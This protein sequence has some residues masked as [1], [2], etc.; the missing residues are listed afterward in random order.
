MENKNTEALEALAII[1]ELKKEIFEEIVPVDKRYNHGR[2]IAHYVVKTIDHL[3]E[4]GLL[5]VKQVT[6]TNEKTNRRN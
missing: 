4:Q 3:Q 6:Q 5:N 2:I 1:D